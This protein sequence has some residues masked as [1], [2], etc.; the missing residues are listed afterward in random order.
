M[1][2]K[3]DTQKH[4]RHQDLGRL[5]SYE[6]TARGILGVT[7]NGYLK[8]TAYTDQ[9]IRVQISESDLF[10]ELSYAVVAEPAQVE[11]NVTE[12]DSSVLIETNSLTVKLNRDPVRLVF[13]NSQGDLL[14]ED[15]PG[16]GISFMGSTKSVYKT[17][18]KEERFI[19]LGEKTGNLDRSGSGYTNHNTD[20]FAY[21][22]ETDPL[23]CSFH[24]ILDFIKSLPM[25]SF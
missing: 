12:N 6:V 18:Q 1:E 17:L 2:I 20:S 24:F 10:D 14:N 19:G 3:S 15:D 25:G 21:G 11:L 13:H 16:F 23:Y 9:I 4:L 8:L 7:E 5:L 22:P